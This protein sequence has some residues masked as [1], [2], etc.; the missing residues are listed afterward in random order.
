MSDE[1]KSANADRISDRIV[2]VINEEQRG[3]VGLIDIFAGQLLALMAINQITPEP[4]PL[5][6]DVVMGAV[7]SC[8]MSLKKADRL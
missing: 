4:R 5:S 7:H 8:L 3:G 1:K 6:F 2:D